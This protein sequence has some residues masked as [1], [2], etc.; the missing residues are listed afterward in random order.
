MPKF[1]A[2]NETQK[3]RDI[4]EISKVVVSS[5]NLDEVLEKILLYARELVDVPA[6]SIALYDQQTA[7][8]TLHAATGLSDKFISRA[9]WQVEEGGLTR[10]ILDHRDLFIIEDTSK[11]DFFY[12]PLAIAEGIQSLIAVPL[13]MQDSIV[14]ILY[15]ND[16][17]PRSFD[18]TACEQLGILVSFASLSIVNARLHEKTLLLASTDGLTGLFN[19]RQFKRIFSQE[20]IR[21]QRY[22]SELS[23]IMIDIDNFKRFNDS[24]GH[25]CG[26]KMLIRVAQLLDEV[27]RDTDMVFR[28]GGEEFV[29][30]LPLSAPV[31]AV[32][33]AERAREAVAS[34]HILCHDVDHPLAVT[35]SVGVASFPHDARTGEALLGVADQLMYQAK[36][37]G[38]N[39]VH[40]VDSLRHV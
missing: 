13:W 30:I 2:P 10:A 6:G 27:F 7:T 29:A 31:D 36:H 1:A 11:A 22:K 17:K 39:R 12:N 19:H 16:F 26:D 20:M 28:Y 33:A 4:I 34:T 25:P 9:S 24:Y 14:G 3:L 23:L 38:K 18:S 8:M 5:L 35:I 21:S 32:I 37:L 40:T 15:L